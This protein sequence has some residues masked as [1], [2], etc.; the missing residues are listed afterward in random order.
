MNRLGRR[1]AELGLGLLKTGL[2]PRELAWSAAAG[3]VLGVF[4][5]PGITT[6]LGLVAALLFGL[7]QPALQLANYLAYPLQLALLMPFFRMGARLFSLEPVP[8]SLPVLLGAFRLDP[9]GTLV[10]MWSMIWHAMVGWAFL[11]L[12][13]VVLLALLLH[14]VFAAAARRARLVRQ[15]PGR[16]Q[17]RPLPGTGPGP[18]L[19]P[20]RRAGDTAG[21]RR[22]D[23]AQPGPPGGG[24]V[25][26]GGP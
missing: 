8:L 2:T 11:A 7:N 6:F 18:P 5:L 20:R 24:G 26:R 21:V 9:F 19:Q 12:P 22:P 25:P 10:R 1:V 3:L 4:P 14:P 15:H 17:H 23:A 16:L 13:A